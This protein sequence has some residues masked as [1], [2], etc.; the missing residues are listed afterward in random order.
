MTMTRWELAETLFGAGFL[1]LWLV[2]AAIVL[3]ALW[4]GLR[5]PDL[6]FS[7]N[8]ARRQA[9]LNAMLL[10]VGVWLR[11]GRLARVLNGLA[12]AGTGLMLA[13]GGAAIWAILG[14]RG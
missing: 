13:A 8:L 5:Q 9:A 7:F 4:A 3:R 2:F 6:M 12:I 14:G 10:E 11:T 1:A